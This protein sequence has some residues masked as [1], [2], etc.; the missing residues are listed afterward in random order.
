[1]S[2]VSGDN[3]KGLYSRKASQI[4]M[5]RTIALP[6]EIDQNITNLA[7]RLQEEVTGVLLYAPVQQ[8]CPIDC[9]LV[10]GI[11]TES[12]VNPLP[13]RRDVLNEFLGLNPSYRHAEYHTHSAGTIRDCG[14]Y[15]ARNFSSGDMATIEGRFADDPNYFHVLFTP[16]RKLVA[17]RDNSKVVIMD[18]LPGYEA[19]SRA[20]TAAI[21][22][23]ARRM[24][25]NLSDL[26]A[27]QIR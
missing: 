24:G 5:P 20:V 27:T 13:R 18:D 3:A 26:P 4:T 7:A 12:Q 21:E 17:S 6:R 15:F 16:I 8:I 23:I 22:A 10:T 1:M 19:R 9:A 25:V 11:G 2:S 14:E